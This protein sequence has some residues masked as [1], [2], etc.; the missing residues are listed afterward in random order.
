MKKLFFNSS[1]E[2]GKLFVNRSSVGYISENKNVWV[3]AD[4]IRNLF[5]YETFYFLTDIPKRHLAVVNGTT[6]VKLKELLRVFKKKNWKQEDRKEIFNALLESVK[7]EFSKQK[8]VV[9]TDVE[10]KIEIDG[11]RIRLFNCQHGLFIS[12][13]DLGD[14]FNFKSQWPRTVLNAKIILKNAE[15][16]MLSDHPEYRWK[17]IE[18]RNGMDCHLFYALFKDVNAFLS[19]IRFH[20]K[21][22]YKRDKYYE[23]ILKIAQ[24]YPGSE[25]NVNIYQFKT[26]FQQ[27]II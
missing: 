19:D 22:A 2:S 18:R 23:Q 11:K 21:Y 14:F 24:K 20:S 8:T 4:D 3:S 1:V 5:C 10:D 7:A 12:L 15:V 27:N 17:D 13:G 26:L 25:P 16:E 6:I 9:K